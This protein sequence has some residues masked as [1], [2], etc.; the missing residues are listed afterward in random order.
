[1]CPNAN[2]PSRQIAV[3]MGLIGTNTE[4]TDAERAHGHRVTYTF[5]SLEHHGERKFWEG[6]EG[7]SP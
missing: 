6:G 5:D 4:V 2:A 7:F 1:M 3:K